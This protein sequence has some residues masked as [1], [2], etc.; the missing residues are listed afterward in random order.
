MLD[1]E[2]SLRLQGFTIGK[3]AAAL[4]MHAPYRKCHS[5]EGL[6][7][8]EGTFRGQTVSVAEFRYEVGSGDMRERYHY[9][10][11]SC[12]APVRWP[13]LTLRP[14]PP[15]YRRRFRD[16][17]KTRPSGLENRSLQ[18]RWNLE[19]ADPRFPVAA[20]NPH[21]QKWLL[22]GSRNEEWSI[23]QGSIQ[24]H[25]RGALD[26]QGVERLLLRLLE[27]RSQLPNELDSW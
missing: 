19:C 1:V 13:L 27:F 23:G 4:A 11:V 22:A 2:H 15:L 14:R 10:A 9:V 16:L 25:H 24:L 6:L 7:W 12:L 26:A 21:L 5:L 8:A 17:F 18:R 3:P 20:M